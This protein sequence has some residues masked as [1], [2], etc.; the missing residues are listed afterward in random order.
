MSPSLTI[1]PSGTISRIVVPLLPLALT[2]QRISTFLAL[3][4]LP[5]S[6]ISWMK[7]PRSTQYIIGPESEVDRDSFG[8][9]T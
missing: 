7:S 2:S 8:N 9:I 6:V 4:T 3:S 5:H 1:D